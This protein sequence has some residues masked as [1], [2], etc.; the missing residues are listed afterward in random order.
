V[1]R[2]ERD[3]LPLVEQD[4]RTLWLAGLRRAAAAPVTTATREV[5]ELRL[6]TLAESAGGR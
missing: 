2:W 6:I 1:P 3:R 4:G 5:V